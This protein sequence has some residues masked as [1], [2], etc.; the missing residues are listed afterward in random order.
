VFIA[1]TVFACVFATGTVLDLF[2]V[3]VLR[4][5]WH[6]RF[7]HALPVFSVACCVCALAQ[8]VPIVVV[9]HVACSAVF[10]WTVG[11][12]ASMYKISTQHRTHPPLRLHPLTVCP[13]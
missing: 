2:A 6:G 1:A 5:L 10:H 4:V 13:C 12:A 9:F 3:R 7:V 11:A 8:D